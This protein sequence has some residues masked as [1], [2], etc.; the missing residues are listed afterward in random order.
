MPSHAGS[1]APRGEAR[2]GGGI[3]SAYAWWRLAAAM[4]LGAIGGVGM[5]SMVVVLPAVQAEFGVA[6]AGASLPYTLVALGLV[7]GGIL[8]GRLAD[9]FGVL[10]PVILGALSLGL[11]YVLVAQAESL[12]AF[13]A[14]YGLLIGLLGTSAVF[15]PLIADVSH[16]FTRRRG[17]AVALCASGNYVAGAFWPPVLQHFVDTAGWRQTHL[18]VGLFCLATMLPLA[19]ALRRPVPA[20][21]PA[22]AAP[23]G[24]EARLDPTREAAGIRPNVLQGMLMLAGVSCCVA[25]SMPQVHIVAYCVDLGYGAARGAEML[26]LMLGFGVVSRL[27]SGWIMDRIGGAATLLLGATLQA[28]ALALFLPFDGLVSLYVISALFGLF[29]GGIIPSYAMITRTLFPAREAGTRIGLV[30]SATLAGMALGGWLSGA[31][32]DATGSYDAAIA[33]GLLWN[34]V[35]IAIAAWLVLRQSRRGRP[36]FA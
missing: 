9:R 6:R 8:M 14:I 24:A 2:D 21:H 22:P 16:W 19:L 34:L 26:A 10:V 15:G 25:M 27:A 17:M 28:A 12:T 11:G 32:F 5:W 29:Q 36:A 13:A 3:E 1:A 7:F 4:A 20:A 30:M 23:S 33:N 18:G 31:I 35:T